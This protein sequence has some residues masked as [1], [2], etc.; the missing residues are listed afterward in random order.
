MTKSI[1]TKK[2]SWDENIGKLIV[3]AVTIIIAVGVLGTLAYFYNQSRKSATELSVLTSTQ[4]SANDLKSLKF[5]S[6]SDWY[7]SY[8]PI[9]D[10]Y[11]LTCTTGSK[12]VTSVK[13]ILPADCNNSSDTKVK[14]AK[15]CY[16]VNR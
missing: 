2:R 1:L 10:I 6:S 13:G 8:D 7:V 14:N 9:T 5:C 12:S 3:F 4:S 15:V 11:W 16:K